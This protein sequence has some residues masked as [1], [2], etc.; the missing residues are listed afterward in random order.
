MVWERQQSSLEIHSLLDEQQI[1][2]GG[3]YVFGKTGIINVPQPKE[4]LNRLVT[5]DP[6]LGNYASILRLDWREIR[7]DCTEHSP[8]IVVLGGVH[9]D[10]HESSDIFFRDISPTLNFSRIEALN[11]HNGPTLLGNGGV[12]GDILPH[13]GISLIPENARELV[14]VA[15]GIG[16]DSITM[17]YRE[18]VKEDMVQWVRQRN[19]DFERV[20]SVQE[21]L[22][23]VAELHAKKQFAE[24]ENLFCSILPE[25]K[26]LC[27]G[28]QYSPDGTVWRLGRKMDLN[29]QFPYTS[30]DTD[31]SD[32]FRN[33]QYPEAQLITKL[34]HD[35]TNI[36]L[37][38]TIHEDSGVG[39]DGKP[40]GFYYYY[41]PAFSE[42][43][44][45]KSEVLNLHSGLVGALRTEGF[46][47]YD[48]VVDPYDPDLGYIS[49]LGLIVSP[50][51]TDNPRG[52]IEDFAAHLGRQG[53]TNL[54][55]AFTFEVP[56]GLSCKEKTKILTI[57]EK[58][59][60]TPLAQVVP[61]L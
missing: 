6:V 16:L 46:G 29:R 51:Y 59:F 42:Q 28:K 25:L 11:V 54:T 26:C 21:Q 30:F 13:G 53:I 37:V 10:E 31:W 36:R 7:P 48:G 52:A 41:T 18:L 44:P 33:V 56:G 20:I 14:V 4:R 24:A 45:L 43:D 32:V 55:G 35:H 39:E 8:Q 49:H 23:I 61:Y 19:T 57:L 47:V 1:V 17:E 34:F 3:S 60:L 15:N 12:R 58:E 38:A 40:K 27:G 50:P 2:G 5:Y 22:E 9:P